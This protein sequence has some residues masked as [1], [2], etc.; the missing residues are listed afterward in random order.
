MA[1]AQDIQADPVVEAKAERVPDPAAALSVTDK[2]N[3]TKVKAE[4]EKVK[5]WKVPKTAKEKTDRRADIEALYAAE[6]GISLEEVERVHLG[7]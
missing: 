2:K 1:K 6:N 4:R 3:A 7:S 5:E